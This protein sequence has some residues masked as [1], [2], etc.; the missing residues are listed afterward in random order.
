M[1]SVKA[2]LAA[3]PLLWAGRVVRMGNDSL[4]KSVLHGEMAGSKRRVGSQI[5]RYHKD[6]HPG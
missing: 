4:P 2:M 3:S 1:P 5:L 6:K